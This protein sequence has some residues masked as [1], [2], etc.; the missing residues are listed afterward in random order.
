ML[1]NLKYKMGKYINN[2][3]MLLFAFEA[4]IKL[5]Y[6]GTVKKVKKLTLVYPK[7]REK[8]CKYSV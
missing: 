3:I 1:S 6:K 2:E 5:H 8:S 4:N 7:V